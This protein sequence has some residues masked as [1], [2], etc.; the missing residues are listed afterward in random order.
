MRR[1]PSSIRPT[2]L[3]RVDGWTDGGSEKGA[4]YPS[5]TAIEFL[6]TRFDSWSVDGLS[7]V[8]SI[9]SVNTSSLSD[10]LRVLRDQISGG[11]IERDT[12]IRLALLAALTGEHL[13]LIGPPGTAKSELARRLRHAFHDATYFER[14]L[15]RFST[16]EELFGPL[17]IKALEQDRYERKTE[18]YLPEAS[19]AFLDEI[20]KA[21]SAIL[22][23][24]LT[25][26][27]ER[28]FDNGK[29]RKKTPLISVVAASNELPDGEELAALY[30][31]FLLRYQVTPVSEGGFNDLLDLRGA[32]GFQ[33]PGDALKLRRE[34]VVQIQSE[35]D[36]VKLPDEVKALLVEFR[37]FLAEQK[38]AVSDR[39]W[40]KIVKLLQT[41]A[42][43]NG[44]QEISIWDCWLLQHCVW[45]KPEQQPAAREWYEK[46]LGTNHVASPARL[47]RLVGTKEKLLAQEKEAQ[48]HA[49][50]EKGKLLY[51]ELGKKVTKKT[52]KRQ[53]LNSQWHPLFVHP[54]Q[55][56]GYLNA[57]PC[58]ETE[59]LPFFANAKD[60]K[61]YAANPDN[62]HFQ[63]NSELEPVMEAASYSAHHIAGRKSD[64]QA[65]LG[66][67]QTYISDLE[68]HI[69][70][71]DSTIGNHLWIQP[72]FSDIAARNLRSTKSEA[73]SLA[74]RMQMV[75]DDC[76]KLP[77]AKE[78]LSESD[79]NDDEMPLPSIEVIKS[80]LL[81]RVCDN[82]TFDDPSEFLTV[83]I[84][85]AE[86]GP[87]RVVLT[88][89]CKLK[90]CRTGTLH[91]CRVRLVFKRE[92]DH[93]T[94]TE[95]NPA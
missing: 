58:T 41:S 48:S 20:F 83:E 86:N 73:T 15:T 7:R 18:H 51:Y 19:V 43:T 26:L 89:K 22:N 35:A 34:D 75:V 21:N 91:D 76:S 62:F 33:A 52:G 29:E 79:E 16:P 87:I 12:P 74:T 61:T 14:L 13:L 60:A 42:L 82:W 39:R 10:K 71:L 46:R 27:N 3:G 9:G 65:I 88:V 56:Q 11:L 55:R 49:R 64:A 4:Q 85:K 94:L 47:I 28:E 44:R 95:Y 57:D 68:R 93:F 36:K 50:N 17:S 78:S 53:K 84:E 92:S 80:S 37:K 24:L 1:G 67:I 30:D 6:N 66:S 31:R 32:G 45:E 59:L 81:G 2:P 70:S 5:E 25:L 63:D 90:G 77:A 8:G 40:R 72:G 54:R 69:A 38:I 23:S